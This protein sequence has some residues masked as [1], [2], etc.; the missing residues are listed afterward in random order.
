MGKLRAYAEL[1]KLKQTFLLA[2]SGVFGYFIAAGLDIDPYVL[3]TFVLAAVLSIAGTTGINM[4]FD[5][6]IDAVMVRTSDRPLPK[7]RISEREALIVSGILVIL[8]VAVGFTV[9][10]WVG[11]AVFLGFL[12]DIAVYTVLLK[13]RTP[14]SVALG[15]IAGGMPIFGG[16]MAYTGGPD[17]KAIFLLGIISLWAIAHIWFIATYF[18]ED[19]AKANVPMLPVVVGAK[20]STYVN[21]VVVLGIFS[22]VLSMFLLDLTTV[23]SLSISLIFTLVI[24]VLALSFVR[25]SNRERIKKAY[26]LLNPYQGLLLLMFWLE[27]IF[28]L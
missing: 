14:W 1:F 5:R 21:I 16:Y 10:F 19:Y 22:I 17:I 23:F 25:S 27:K 2:Y 8:G 3:G 18:V 6:D 24:I 20:R 15:A 7:Q 12:I 26:K 13:R 28:L 11:I 9:N 4:Y